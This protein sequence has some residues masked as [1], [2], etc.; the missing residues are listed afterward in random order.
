MPVKKYCLRRFYDLEV[1]LLAQLK[2]TVQYRQHVEAHSITQVKY[3]AEAIQEK[4]DRD[5]YSKSASKFYKKFIDKYQILGD[6]KVR[7]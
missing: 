1:E 7:K 6:E 3:V 5:P 4:L 2:S